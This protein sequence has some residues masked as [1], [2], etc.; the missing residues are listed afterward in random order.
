MD[1]LL[2]IRCCLQTPVKVLIIALAALALLPLGKAFAADP[3]PNSGPATLTYAWA[4]GHVEGQLWGVAQGDLDGD[5]RSE[6]L[7]LERGLVRI[8]RF[9]EKAFDQLFACRWQEGAQAARIGL[10]DLEGDGREEV[11]ISAVENGLP[12]SMALRIDLEHQECQELFSRARWSLRVAEVPGDDGSA[13]RALLGQAWS[14]AQFFDG[15]VQ[16]LRVEGKRL[17]TVLKLFLPKRVDLF[18]FTYLF[19]SD[20]PR[21]ALV[22]GINPLEV[23]EQQGARWRR[24]W[25]A[26]QRFGGTIN[27][28]PASQRQALDQESSQDVLFAIPPIALPGGGVLAV[29]QDIPL[30]DI[31]GRRSYIRSGTLMAFVPEEVLGYTP[32]FSTRELPGAAID[33]SPSLAAPGGRVMVLMQE[34]AGAFELSRSSTVIGF[35]LP[36]SSFVLHR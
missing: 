18:E 13:R 36:N 2:R 12:A 30:R 35:D 16:E 24:I 1:D 17:Q 5:G 29:R 23:Q 27:A 32:S 33:L 19:G 25:R 28:L 14:Q 21:V 8:G 26:G 11:V 22:R 34:D 3:Q 4:G 7:L 20:T 6:A 15:Q 10:I 9:G 31:V